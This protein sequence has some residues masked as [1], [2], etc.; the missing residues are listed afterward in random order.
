MAG[1]E[2]GIGGFQC[3]SGHGSQR[4]VVFVRQLHAFD[5]GLKARDFFLDLGGESG[6]RE[7]R[8]RDDAEYCQHQERSSEHRFHGILEL[9][10]KYGP[11]C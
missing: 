11:Q 7:N 6:L 9:Q 4:L 5:V 3:V 1:I 8:R 2:R 10:T